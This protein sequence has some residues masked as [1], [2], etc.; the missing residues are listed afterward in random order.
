MSANPGPLPEWEHATCVVCPAQV[1]GPGYFDVVARPGPQYRYDPGAGHR[2]NVDTG[3]PVCVH[4][5][6][7]GLPPG[8]YASAAV[9]VPATDQAAPQPGAE[10][11]HLPEHVCDLEGWIIAVLRVADPERMHS[12]LAAAERTA[13]Q[14]FPAK[15]VVAAMRRV[16]AY[17]LANS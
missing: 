1:L 2:T 9:P 11:L 15:D 6:R 16:L 5:F 17:E 13:S 14:R 8:A 7:V 12:A 4:P 3:V 10:Q